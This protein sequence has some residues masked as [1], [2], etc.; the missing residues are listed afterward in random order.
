M[1]TTNLIQIKRSFAT[2]VPANNDIIEGELAYSFVAASN[3]MFIGDQANVAI[4]VAGGKYEWL[5][6][7]NVSAPGTL[8]ANAVVVLNGNGYVTEARANALRVGADGTTLVVNQI[9]AVSNSTTLGASANNELA[10]T[11]A[12][13]TYVTGQVAS[14]GGNVTDRHVA[15]S[16]DGVLSGDAGF[17]YD[18]NNNTLQLG[19]SGD[20]RMYIG[21]TSGTY[22][23][24][25]NDA[26]DFGGNITTPGIIKINAGGTETVTLTVPT[27]IAV[28]DANSY[29][30]I[31]AQNKNTGTGAS[32]DFVAYPDNAGAND[33]NG[34]IDMGIGSSTFADPA[35]SVTGPNEGYVFM[36]APAGSGSS[37]DLVIATDSSGT[38][39][40]IRFYANGYDQA[41]N[42]YAVAIHGNN[43]LE[44]KNTLVVSGPS[45]VNAVSVGGTLGVTGNANVA[46]TLG[47]A[48]A[49][50]VSNT[51]NVTALATL[52][53]ANVTG[54]IAVQGNTTLGSDGGDSVVFTASI[55]SSVLPITDG[56]YN[57]GNTTHRWATAYI[58]DA[59]I[60]NDITIGGNTTVTGTANVGAMNISNDLA[61]G[62]NLIV[63]GTLTTINSET[64][65]ISD[66]LIRV[67]NGNLTTDTVDVGF[68]GSYGNTTVTEYTGLFRDSTDGFY[69]LFDSSTAEPTTTV[70]TAG[71]G[72]NLATL[73]LGRVE[74]A[75]ANIVTMESANVVI[76]GG[77]ITGITDLL[78]ADG[79][80][81]VS[82][83]TTNGV[84]FGNGS[85]AL[86][87]TAAGA[88]GTILQSVGGVPQFGT[89]D[90]GSF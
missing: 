47:V 10:T 72:F 48:G 70:D 8:T 55:G 26:A 41:I 32:F 73:V 67:A 16:Q 43:Q 33:V 36:S 34:F 58:D 66:P 88:N 76:T 9:N 24:I 25:Q 28:T 56:T 65:N 14:V 63:Q 86:Q 2:E 44:V 21:N 87:V 90:G 68:Y 7:A 31:A 75:S 81:G 19:E 57:L 3:S 61:V 79:G 84:I 15:Y 5:H 35:Y 80:T 49:T 62:G 42:S 4:R 60:T 51:L 20:G 83:F 71:N 37:G 78:V 59:T 82:T 53:Q 12:I 29:S 52:A 11:F 50:E 6:Q 22:T 40:K 85:G 64:L 89:L 74:G 46:G 18:A 77:S 54:D 30:Q 1:S 17:Q 45:V 27:F 13:E 69:R 39:N 23:S 38:T